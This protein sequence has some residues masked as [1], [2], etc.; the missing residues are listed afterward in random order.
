M[1]VVGI[2]LGFACPDCG[3]VTAKCCPSQFSLCECCPL[4]CLYIPQFQMPYIVLLLLDYWYK[5]FF[6]LLSC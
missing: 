5:Y 4:V 1:W 3:H 2:L 6:L